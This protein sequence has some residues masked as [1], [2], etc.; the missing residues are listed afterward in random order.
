MNKMLAAL[1]A[2]ALSVAQPAWAT[3]FATL[4]TIYV[5]SGVL[6]NGFGAGNGTATSFHCTNASGLT[7]QLRFL[8]LGPGGNALGAFNRT[9]PHANTVT[10][11]THE[12]NAYFDYIIMTPGVAITQGGIVIESTQSGVF[13]TAITLDAGSSTP[14]GFPLHLVRINPHPGSVE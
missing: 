2:A 10:A 13:C 9:L 12:T 3:T 14:N 7:A 11:S 6:D 8:L 4:T 1:T 5:G